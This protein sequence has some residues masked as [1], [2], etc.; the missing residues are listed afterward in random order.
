LR[1]KVSSAIR[2]GKIKP[3]SAKSILSYVTGE[4]GLG[5]DAAAAFTERLLRDI[6]R[7]LRSK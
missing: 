4:F 1:E 7:D 6:H 5:D 2:D 3:A